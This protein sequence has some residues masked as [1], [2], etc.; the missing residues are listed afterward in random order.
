MGPQ[1]A[2]VKLPSR[3]GSLPT[4]DNRECNI[5]LEKMPV[6]PQGA[7]QKS[8]LPSIIKGLQKNAQALISKGWQKTPS[9]LHAFKQQNEETP[10][11]KT[12]SKETSDSKGKLRIVVKPP[13]RAPMSPEAVLREFKSCLT[14]HEL[15]EIRDYKEVWYWGN[16][17]NKIKTSQTQNGCYTAIINDHLAYRFQILEVIGTG[18]SGE[19]IKC[20]DHK[21]KE[22]VAVKVFRDNS[23]VR[24]QGE[25]E[26]KI[27]KTLRKC[28]KD[29][30]ANIVHIK[31][32]FYFRQHLCITFDLFDE[33]LYRALKRTKKPGFSERELRKYTMDMLKCLQLLKKNN[34]VHGDL[35]TNNILV[36]RKD[37][38]KHVAVGDYGG[39][40]LTTE[41][42][43]PPI[44]TLNYVAPE[45]LLGKRCSPAIDMW[46]LGCIL[47]EL[48][49]GHLLF[50]GSNNLCQF[51]HIME[52]LGVPPSNLLDKAP[53]RDM[54]FDSEG[55]P[56]QMEKITRNSTTLA[57]KLGSK[58]AEFVD[59]IEG[60]LQ[61]NPKKRMTP[62]QAMH[63]PWITQ[64]SKYAAAAAKSRSDAPVSSSGKKPA[65]PITEKMTPVQ[66]GKA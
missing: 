15:G 20:L 33:D 1:P 19:V 39:S 12:T 11:S 22:R 6:V 56:L 30:S 28:D 26:V 41:S 42:H 63:H 53:N 66:P 36:L 43:K 27:L 9:Y 59:F 31:E 47:A 46:S 18:Y 38:E 60:C 62:E 52:V 25:A 58:N 14:K 34:I 57:K 32:K 16:K 40:Y 4:G 5:V 49:I 55:L 44:H 50:I 35:K 29:R 48:H 65:P 64:K 21:T 23:S 13:V 8:S 51:R 54:F 37:R 45:L 10:S 61:Y 2:A 17:A 7:T 3:R 24:R